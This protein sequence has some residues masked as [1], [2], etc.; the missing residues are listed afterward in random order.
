MLRGAP[1]LRPLMSLVHV[2]PPF[3]LWKGPLFVPT[4]ILEEFDGLILMTKV[5]GKKMPLM[6]FRDSPAIR[7]QLPPPFVLL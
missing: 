7:D 3:V 1:A 5:E 6:V 4:K 2:A